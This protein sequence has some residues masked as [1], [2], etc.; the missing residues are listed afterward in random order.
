MK[1]LSDIKDKKN[2]FNLS[3]ENFLSNSFLIFNQK[4][5]NINRE[6]EEIREI[7]KLIIDEGMVIKFFFFK[8]LKK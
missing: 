5:I 6:L 2:S 1:S 4:T 3:S 7:F 8:N